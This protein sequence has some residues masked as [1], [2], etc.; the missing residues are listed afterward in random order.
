LINFP[1]GRLQC[2][3]SLRHLVLLTGELILIA[4]ELLYAAP[5]NGK[6]NH[7]RLNLRLQFFGWGYGCQPAERWSPSPDHLTAVGLPSKGRTDTDD[8]R[9]AK[10]AEGAKCSPDIRWPAARDWYVFGT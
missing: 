3:E 10:T 9:D 6:I 1:H 4:G 5:H 2:S 7:H 8:N